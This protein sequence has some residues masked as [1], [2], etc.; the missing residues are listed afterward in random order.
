MK[1]SD[2]IVNAGQCNEEFVRFLESGQ[3]PVLFVDI[4]ETLIHRDDYEGDSGRVEVRT[5]E[6]THYVALRPSA[7]G[8]LEKA[9]K[10]FRLVA[11]TGGR[12]EFQAAMLFSVGLNQF[13]EQIVGRDN[14][15]ELVVPSYFVLLDDLPL[16]HHG[17]AEKVAVLGIEK[18]GL[19]GVQWTAVASRHCVTCVKFFGGAD[20]QS[21]L[22]L[23]DKI[24]YCMELQSLRKPTNSDQ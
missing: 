8:F 24:V 4:D 23:W 2:L 9:G 5:R 12:R 1:L 21:L 16:T 11:L 3:K 10:Y 19:T 7:R 22:D 18:L 15:D 17:L 20:P 13:F 6:S 14:H